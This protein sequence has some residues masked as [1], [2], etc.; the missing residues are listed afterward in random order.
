MSNRI[1]SLTERLHWLRA[2][3]D[4]LLQVASSPEGLGA[5][6]ESTAD[7]APLRSGP[8]RIREEIKEQ[9]IQLFRDADAAVREAQG[10]KDSVRELAERWK[11]IEVPA[12][13][14]SSARQS[15]PARVDHLGSSTFIEKGWARLVVGDLEAARESLERALAMAPE[16]N[17]AETLLGWANMLEGK[18]ELA[19]HSTY[20][21]L[22]RDPTYAL[23]RTNL[24]YLSLK[25]GDADEAVRQLTSVLQADTDRRASLYACLYLAMAYQSLGRYEHAEQ[26]YKA[27]IERGPNL[28]QSWYELGQLYWAGGRHDEAM[29]AWRNGASANKFSPWG[30]RCA[31]QLT[32]LESGVETPSGG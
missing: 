23:A 15:G 24:G 2:D 22:G 9:I 12:D 20:R 17:E 1:E 7:N 32:K 5:E 4:N 11:S 6:G 10:L 25:R 19:L 14:A 26:C 16:S 28:L 18:L 30:K 13:A 8:A 31:E 29:T 3:L 27:A 21:V